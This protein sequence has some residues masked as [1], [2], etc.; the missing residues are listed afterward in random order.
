MIFKQ[1]TTWLSC[2]FLLLLQCCT[3]KQ[4]VEC[5]SL[6]KPPSFVF[7]EPQSQSAPTPTKETPS[8]YSNCFE[9]GQYLLSGRPSL[10]EGLN[11]QLPQNSNPA[12]IAIQILG[13]VKGF[14]LHNTNSPKPGDTR[15]LANQL[16][17]NCNTDKEKAE[18]I[19]DFITKNFKDWWYPAEGY[20]EIVR[21]PRNIG[22]QLWGYG[23]GFC[24]D[25]GQI[26]AALWREAG[27]KAKITK[28]HPFH[29]VASVFYD[30]SWHVYDLQHRTF[31]EK[32]DGAVAS[33]LEM[34]GRPNLFSQNLDEYGYDPIG[35]PP[36]LEA[37][38]Y[39]ESE[40]K[41][42][43][44]KRWELNYDFSLE[45]RDGESFT[46]CYLG[47]PKVYHPPMWVQYYGEQTRNRNPPWPYKGLQVYEPRE[48]VVYQ[49]VETNDGET[50]YVISMK[51]PFLFTD[52]TVELKG[53]T[54]ETLVYVW[55]HN[56]LQF[57]T[58][59]IYGV[60]PIGSQIEGTR[61]FSVCIV[62]KKPYANPG[63][64]L[65]G[66]TIRAETQISHLTL[67]KI[68]SG[69][70]NLIVEW[71]TGQPELKLWYRK[72]AQDLSVKYRSCNPKHPK[73]GDNV[74]LEYVVVNRGLAASLPTTYRVR[75]LTTALLA[76]SG[77]LVG[78]GQI[79]PIEPGGQ[80]AISISW[81]ANTRQTWYGQNPLHQRFDIWID[82]KK[83]VTDSNRSD[84]RLQHYVLL[85]DS[86]PP[87]KNK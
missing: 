58:P 54:K 20:Q 83:N 79:P 68:Q 72:L 27:L 9:S 86:E 15:S 16:I 76:E 1:S 81:T 77:E 29:T 35:Y 43:R 84:Q 40:I 21:Y 32:T 17:R 78:I 70:N 6:L 19:F 38:W 12:P 45:L 13:P 57:V 7:P 28:L 87:K 42:H 8:A 30:G 80:C 41:Y 25:S 44:S 23:Y 11:F 5:K 61:A 31:W 63:E 2:S 74:T 64:R 62:P 67:P 47:N 33:E 85:E 22:V 60:A 82:E 39:S 59:M 55:S 50:A 53:E 3:S 46:F 56:H 51:S 49:E 69:S 48:Q 24:S 73:V 26:A 36:A 34:A 14:Y 37:K 66:L 10:G 4:E 18:A 52:G 71:Q 65:K 75:N